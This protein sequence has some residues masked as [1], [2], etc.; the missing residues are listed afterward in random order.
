V[1]TVVSL[2][3]VQLSAGRKYWIVAFPAE[4]N[5]FVVWNLNAVDGTGQGGKNAENLGPAWVVL[6]V[7]FDGLAFDVQG[8][9]EYP[10]ISFFPQVVVGG[11]YSTSFAVTNTGRTTASGSLILTDPQGNPLSVNGALTDSSGITRPSLTGHAYSRN[12]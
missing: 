6:D 11:G 9:A 3:N 8:S 5:T 12:R 2:P 4:S 7:P 1:Q 10:I